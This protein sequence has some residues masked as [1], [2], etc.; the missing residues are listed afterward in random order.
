M[1]EKL[2]RVIWLDATEHPSGWY[3]Y[4][5]A[6]EEKPAICQSIGWIVEMTDEF[7]TLAADKGSHEEC[8]RMITLPLGMIEEIEYL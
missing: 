1:K 3:S 4:E 5:E 2:V 7:I 8:G 6:K